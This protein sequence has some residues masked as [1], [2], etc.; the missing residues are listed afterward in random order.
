MYRNHTETIQHRTEIIGTH[1]NYIEIIQKMYRKHAKI[2]NASNNKAI[3]IIW[4]IAYFG[5]FSVHFL[6]N[7]CIISV[8]SYDFC[9][10]LY[11]FCMFFFHRGRF[12][13]IAKCKPLLY[14]F[15]HQTH[16]GI[17]ALDVKIC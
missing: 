6:Y 13:N 14:V 5:T 2:C 8:C 16:H 7:F 15:I 10:V 17:C 1:R 12:Q 11:D 3:L 4:G 9:T